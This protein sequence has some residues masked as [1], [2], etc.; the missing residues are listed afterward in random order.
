MRNTIIRNSWDDASAYILLV[1]T[2]F[3]SYAACE[4]SDKVTTNTTD[5]T[6]NRLIIKIDSSTFNATLQDNPTNWSYK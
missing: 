2:V 3:F 6:S 1:D 4:K 5:M